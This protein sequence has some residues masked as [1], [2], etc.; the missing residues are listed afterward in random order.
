MARTKAFDEKETLL[1]AME[2]FWKKGFHATS[3]QDLVDHLGINRASLYDTY[4]GKQQL[5]DNA[6]SLYRKQSES[7]MQAFL[8]QQKSV[9]I[10]LYNLFERSVDEA[11][12]DPEHKGCF[13]V[14][15]TAELSPGDEYMRS[16]LEENRNRIEGIFR[17]YLEKGVASGEIESGKN[18]DDI[19][20]LIFTLY[21]GINILSKIQPDK[22]KLMSTV[23][24][25]L[26]V[27]D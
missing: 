26:A 25:G 2:L 4:G 11:V 9:K 24:T 10:G 14:N 6:F 19:A 12:R 21:N 8:G 20:G 16:L 17:S 1:K 23:K 15:T 27:L 13:V 5:F 7:S 18:V 3:M 22:N